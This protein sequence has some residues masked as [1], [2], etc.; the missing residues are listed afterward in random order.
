MPGFGRLGSTHPR[1]ALTQE[2]PTPTSG[3]IGIPRGSGVTPGPR[4]TLEL[5]DIPEPWDSPGVLG[6]PQC[7]AG[8]WVWALVD[9]NWGCDE[10]KE[11]SAA[12]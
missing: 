6:Y 1:T 12:R 3:V 4:D 7:L 8:G 2:D 5:R 10:E 9:R 11:R